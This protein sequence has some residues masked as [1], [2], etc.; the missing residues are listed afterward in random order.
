[1]KEVRYFALAGLCLLGGLGVG[2][3]QLAKVEHKVQIT[4]P[5]AIK[6]DPVKIE[7]PAA[8]LLAAIRQTQAGPVVVGGPAPKGVTARPH[9]FRH[10]AAELVR[11]RVS[12]EL[13]MKGFAIAGGDMTPLDKDEADKWAEKLTDQLIVTSGDVHGGPFGAGEDGPVLHFVVT[14][15]KWLK[16]N[17]EFIR[18]LLSLL[19]LIDADGGIMLVF[20]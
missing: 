4:A 14:I 13:Q 5:A 10:L 9:P 2:I 17:P 7:V 15:L 16:D 6:I 20:W 8:D 1:V 12:A 11:R 3:Y 18:F 19:M